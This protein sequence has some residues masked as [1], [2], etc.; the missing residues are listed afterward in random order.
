V[1]SRSGRSFS[2][3]R[4][5]LADADAHEN[6]S[7]FSGKNLIHKKTWPFR[8]ECCEVL[9]NLGYIDLDWNTNDGPA[10]GEL[11][12]GVG[13]F[14][15]EN[16]TSSQAFPEGFEQGGEDEAFRPLLE[17]SKQTPEPQGESVDRLLSEEEL[18]FLHRLSSLEGEFDLHRFS[19]EQISSGALLS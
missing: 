1:Q 19:P 12:E 16:Q 7:P 13:W 11:A 2:H 17:F 18:S 3:N 14:R 5:V 8:L 9:K 4:H 10:P 6:L 15:E